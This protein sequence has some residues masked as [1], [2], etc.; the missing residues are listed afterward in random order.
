MMHKKAYRQRSAVKAQEM[1]C[2]GITGKTAPTPG[3]RED[4]VRQFL[5]IKI[6]LQE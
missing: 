5:D 4:E 1:T 6:T 2:L 3:Q